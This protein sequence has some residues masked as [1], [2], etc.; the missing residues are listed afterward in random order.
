MKTI[1]M[2]ILVVAVV[3]LGGGSRVQTRPT[4]PTTQFV[5]T[6][7]CGEAVRAF[8]GGEPC[9]SIIWRLDLGVT[10]RGGPGWSL[11]AAQGA[12]SAAS[13][14]T[15]P[16][17]LHLSGKL[18]KSG[19]TYRLISNS[20]KSISFR[21]VSSTLIHLLDDQ[22]RLMPGTSAWSYTLSRADVTDDPGRPEQ[23]FG[24]SYTLSPRESGNT[25]FGIFGGRTPCMSLVRALHITL[26]DGCQRLKW[27]VTLLQNA[28]TRE[29]TRYK[30]EGSLHHPAREGAWHIVHGTATDADAVVYQLD[31]TATEAPMLLWKADDNVLF[32]LDERKQPLVGTI[33]FSYTLSRSP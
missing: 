31:G 29:P 12:N 5:G 7:P 26:N 8:I 3:L 11:I 32:L 15:M 19:T 27:R 24:G 2:G 22:N 13:V 6:M 1:A 20:G 10:E 17:G 21:Q 25:L 9:Q 30:I 23:I 33:D 28:S 4:S 18:E 14:G 16:D